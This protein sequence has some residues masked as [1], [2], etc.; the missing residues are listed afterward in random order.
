M[1]GPRG[2]AGVREIERPGSRIEP[3]MRG[4]TP[5][6]VT[7]DGHS[8]QRRPPRARAVVARLRAPSVPGP[9]PH[10]GRR[11]GSQARDGS[12]PLP[13]SGRPVP[14]PGRRPGARR[15]RT[16]RGPHSSC[17]LRRIRA[18]PGSRSAEGRA[19]ASGGFHA[20]PRPGGAHTCRGPP[21]AR[22]P[23]R[24]AHRPRSAPPPCVVTCLPLP[25]P[26]A[27]CRPLRPRVLPAGAA[28]W[29]SPQRRVGKPI[30]ESAPFLKASR[31]MAR[32]G[33]RKEN[34]L[35]YDDSRPL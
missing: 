10:P 27:P 30:T 32:L 16:A 6:A 28:E 24:R 15:A 1:G 7:P 35:R 20:P 33:R 17:L 5:A 34:P 29:E 21:G 9:F 25:P 3:R 14:P 11:R 19:T 31:C 13:A 23:A 12:R 2:R 26:V 8:A 22:L 4:S 18:L